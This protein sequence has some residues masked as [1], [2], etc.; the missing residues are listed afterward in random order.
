MQNNSI[1][2]TLGMVAELNRCFGNEPWYDIR[3]DKNT[4]HAYLSG[5]VSLIIEEM[6]DELGVAVDTHDIPSMLDAIGDAITVIDGVVHKAGFDPALAEHCDVVSF[7]QGCPP[8]PFNIKEFQNIPSYVHDQEVGRLA[9]ELWRWHRTFIEAF[10]IAWGFDPLK[11]Y[12]EVHQSN[13]SKFCVNLTEVAATLE[14]YS[15]QYGLSSILFTEE[16]ADL[17]AT[18][19]DVNPALDLR[20]EDVNGVYVIKTN[21]EVT[22]GGKVVK[23]GKFLKGINFKEPDFSQPERFKLP[24]LMLPT[25]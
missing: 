9:F 20:V 13:M 1:M 16:Y 14:K 7:L 2:T 8:V 11:V 4:Y 15:E 18:L 19:L 3:G 12:K 6:Y 5:Q 17:K 21:R 23:A 22:M 24:Q 10:S 25:L